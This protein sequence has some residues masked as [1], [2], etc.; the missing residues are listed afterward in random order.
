MLVGGPV[1][2]PHQQGGT[3]QPSFSFTSDWA[4]GFPRSPV[5]RRGGSFSG[6]IDGELTM[7]RENWQLLTDDPVEFE[8]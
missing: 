7:I 1:A 5:R 2:G 8:K 4:Q 6:K 3:F